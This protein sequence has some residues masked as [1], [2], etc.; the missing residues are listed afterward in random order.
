MEVLAQLR[1]LWPNFSGFGAG[2]TGGLVVIFWVLLVSI[3]S[4]S[5][6]QLFRHFQNF[7][8]RL[9]TLVGLIDGQDKA[10][11]AL[12]RR[13]TEQDAMRQDPKVVGPLW[14][15]FDE[16]LVLSHDNQQLFNTLDA[17]HFFN[18]RTLAMGLTGSRL[19]A[20]APSFLVAIGVLGTFVGLT[21]GLDS[22]NLD[23]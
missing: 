10:S 23:S 16:T 9:H 18:A 12:N 7:T 4:V 5:G 17:D 19:L 8:A 2:E 14:R 22:I 21:V 6:V 15:E 20:A 11:L 3:F 1:H 13:E